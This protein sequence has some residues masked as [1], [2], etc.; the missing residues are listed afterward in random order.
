M[1]A[2]A[3]YD[4]LCCPYEAA[5]V[6]EQAA[7]CLFRLG[8]GRAPSLLGAALAA[9][10]ELGARWDLDRAS[11]LARLHGVP[12]PARHRRGPHGYGSDL[13]PREEETARLAATGL[14][15]KEIAKE[16]FLSTKTVDKHLSAALRKL[17]LRSRSAL[18]R[19]L[20][21]TT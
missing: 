17:G 13:S 10:G 11:R 19:R 16:L 18:A 2:A 3:A 12:S 9:Y 14:T 21:D 4:R 7:S 8:D 15:N 5:Q 20:D 1:S 6:R